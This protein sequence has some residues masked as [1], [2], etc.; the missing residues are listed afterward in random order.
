MNPK[1]QTTQERRAHMI[2]YQRRHRAQQREYC[3]RWRAR[4]ADYWK[5]HRPEINFRARLKEHRLSREAFAALLIEQA[6]RCW[7]CRRVLDR[8]CI[9]HDHATGRIRGLLCSR[10]NT[11][12]GLA[13]D[14]PGRLRIAADY[15]ER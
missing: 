12:I 4:N 15:L 3:R 5:Q 1:K 11:M 8:P 10:C 13:Q 9:D 7:I 2:E 14:E 6:G